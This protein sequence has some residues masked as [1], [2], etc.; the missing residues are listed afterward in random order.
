MNRIAIHHLELSLSDIDPLL[1]EGVREA[2]PGALEHLL[3][4]TLARRLA[5][6]GTGAVSLQI[7]SA[8]LGTLDLPARADAHAAAKAIAA[9][10]ADWVDVRVGA[11]TVAGA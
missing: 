11:D 3:E 6:A 9:R 5:S 7:A 10:L 4:R 1:A 8:D 2:L